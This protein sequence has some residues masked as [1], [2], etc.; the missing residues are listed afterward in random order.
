MLLVKCTLCIGVTQCAIVYALYYIIVR[1]I[2]VRML[3]SSYRYSHK[4][5]HYRLLSILSM[6]EQLHAALTLSLY[7]VH[8]QEATLI[9]DS[10][11]FAHDTSKC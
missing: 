2:I 11:A 1:Y 3:L 8:T 7:H 10:S 9:F 6:G 5:L 4:R